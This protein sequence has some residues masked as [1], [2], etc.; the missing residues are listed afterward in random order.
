MYVITI[1]G[2]DWLAK[3]ITRNKLA[4]RTPEATSLA[5]QSAFNKPTVR[6]FFDKLK[7]VYDRYVITVRQNVK[8]QQHWRIATL[9]LHD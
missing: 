7:E 4:I 5:R 9:S 6:K 3:F 2:E 8:L 1:A